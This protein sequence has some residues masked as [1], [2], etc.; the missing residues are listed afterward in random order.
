MRPYSPERFRELLLYIADRMAHTDHA[1]RGRIKLVKMIWLSDFEA[2]L[3]LGD[4]ITGAEYRS[5]KLG[6]SPPDELIQTR[7]LNS[8]TEFAYEPGYDRQQL[9]IA[10]RPARTELF[11]AREL[12]LVNEVVDRYRSWTADRVVKEIAHEHPG[13]KLVKLGEVV[14]YDSVF[15][16]LAPPSPSTVAR[17]REL[18]SGGHGG[19]DIS[20]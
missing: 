3:K 12:E 14:P 5:D 6:P 20:F 4:A 8:A 13:Y 16:S 17:A 15:I 1:G 9:P 2:Y 10:K 11:D 19:D 18:V 7:T